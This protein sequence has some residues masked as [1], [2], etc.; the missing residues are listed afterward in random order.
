MNINMFDIRIKLNKLSIINIQERVIYPLHN[1]MM[2]DDNLYLEKRNS[3]FDK[4]YRV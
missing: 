2:V 3:W 1:A 4:S